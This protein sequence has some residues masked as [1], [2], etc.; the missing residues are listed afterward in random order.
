MREMKAKFSISRATHIHN[1]LRNSQRYRFE[2]CE[3]MMTWNKNY[4]NALFH[5][6]HQQC[7]DVVSARTRNV[8]LCAF[9]A[10]GNIVRV[11]VVHAAHVRV[12][13]GIECD[14]YT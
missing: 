7:A 1:S 10:K 9:I 12:S 2:R 3:S 14:I 8:C 13:I 4:I 11:S 6:H 5:Q